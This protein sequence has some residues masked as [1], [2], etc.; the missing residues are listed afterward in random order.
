MG[1]AVGVAL[2]G[3]SVGS[4]VGKAVGIDVY[5]EVGDEVDMIGEGGKVT[6]VGEGVMSVGDVGS[7][8]GTGVQSGVCSLPSVGWRVGWTWVGDKLLTV[9]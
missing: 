3:S 4:L 5:I 8:V 7:T 6:C 9:G 1:V 2:V